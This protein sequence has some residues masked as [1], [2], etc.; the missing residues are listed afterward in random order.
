MTIARELD[1][2]QQ[3]LLEFEF[4]RAAQSAS[5]FLTG[6]LG[7]TLAVLALELP[8]VG[9]IRRTRGHVSAEELDEALLLFGLG[10][11]VHA[12]VFRAAASTHRAVS[13]S[14]IALGSS[15]SFS[16]RTRTRDETVA[17]DGSRRSP[18]RGIR[19]GC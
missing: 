3:W 13:L 11:L 19:S 2:P 12:L 1:R 9:A 6:H 15:A 17:A 5:T 7:G 4:G 10:T 8:F 16:P 14:L 18:A